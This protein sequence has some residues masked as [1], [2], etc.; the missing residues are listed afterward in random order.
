MV[1]LAWLLAAALAAA[2]GADARARRAGSNPLD[3]TGMWIWQ[4]P[5]S[6]GGSPARIGAQARSYGV[7]TVYLKSSDGTNMWRQFTPAYVAALKAQGLKVCAWQYVYGT[8]PES[9]AA[10]GARAVQYGADCLIIDAESEY[11]G[12]Y[13]Q[14]DR[15]VR[16][17]RRAIGASYPLAVSPFPY[18]DYHPSFPYSVFLG[19]NG[20]QYNLPQMYWKAI[21]TSVDQVFAHTYTYNRL[22]GRRIYPLGQLYQNPSAP[23]VRRFRALADAYGASGVNWWDWQEARPGA[24][25]ALS[26]PLTVKASA[27]ALGYPTLA[28]GSRGDLVVWAQQHL[29][30]AGF[31]VRIDGSYGATTRNAVSAFQAAK[32]TPVTGK[33]GEISWPALLRYP[34]AP[35]GWGARA[36]GAATRTSAGTAPASARLPA[37]ARE[38]PPKRHGRG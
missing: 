34:A 23:Q 31:N 36:R 1:A 18:V 15:Y 16:T 30:S 2:G 38:I 10:L 32:G 33:I 17:L 9:E 13:A 25:Q 19:P 22:Y 4:A 21:G 6:S 28:S 24:W 20:A 29:V 14:A 35:V 3:G 37:L 5:L 7:R 26:A 11:E 27:P 8:R 12:R